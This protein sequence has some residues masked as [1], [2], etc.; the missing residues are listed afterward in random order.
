MT[1]KINSRTILLLVKSS[2]FSQY[3]EI[4][5]NPDY[6]P[7]KVAWHGSHKLGDRA[8]DTY[9]DAWH[10]SSSDRYGLGSPLTGGR[11]LEQVRYSCDNKFALLCIEV[12]SELVRRRR[13]ADIRPDDDVEMSEDDY[14][15][16]L[17]ELMQYW[18]LAPSTIHSQR[19]NPVVM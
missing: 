2:Q 9:C 5:V 14:M 11:L 19:E 10:S 1:N 12:T 17:E 18:I 13:S 4:N 15:E 16:Y 6:R 7:E 8:M 3:R